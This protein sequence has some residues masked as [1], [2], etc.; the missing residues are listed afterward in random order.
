VATVSLSDGG[1]FLS[2]L[3]SGGG[4]F[5]EEN[6]ASHIKGKFAANLKSSGGASKNVTEGYFNFTK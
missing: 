1:D 2:A 5:I 6:D 3:G 4:L